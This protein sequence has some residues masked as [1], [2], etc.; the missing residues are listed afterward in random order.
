MGEVLLFRAK[1]QKFLYNQVING[2]QRLFSFVAF[3][4]EAFCDFNLVKRG[5]QRGSWNGKVVQ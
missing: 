4:D 5:M 1:S 2:S 3:F